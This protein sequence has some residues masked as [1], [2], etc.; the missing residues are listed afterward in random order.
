MAK[1][2]DSNVD[3]DTYSWSELMALSVG[4]ATYADVLEETKVDEETTVPASQ[5]SAKVGA[6]YGNTVGVVLEE[7]WTKARSGGGDVTG[8]DTYASTGTN[9]ATFIDFGTIAEGRAMMITGEINQAADLG[10]ILYSGIT[11]F[12]VSARRRAGGSLSGTLGVL[13]GGTG[14]PGCNYGTTGNVL[15]IDSRLSLGG[16]A[17]VYRSWRYRVDTIEMP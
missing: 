6:L 15:T 5:I 8:T 1:Y 7:I 11:Q 14:S 10:G 13:T 17:T 12:R 9:Y 4:D 3:I 16:S 2:T